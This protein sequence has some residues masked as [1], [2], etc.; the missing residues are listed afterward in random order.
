MSLL[1]ARKHF[2][3]PETTPKELLLKYIRNGGP[4]KKIKEL[5]KNHPHLLSDPEILPNAT[6][7]GKIKLIKYLINRGC[8]LNDKNINIALN[9]LMYRDKSSLIIL[10]YLIETVCRK[11]KIN[12]FHINLLEKATMFRKL[13]IIT[14]LAKHFYSKEIIKSNSKVLLK[15]LVF[16]S[17]LLKNNNIN[18][19]QMLQCLIQIGCDPKDCE[20][21]LLVWAIT[22]QDID[23]LKYII[24]MGCDPK[25]IGELSPYWMNTLRSYEIIKYLT[26]LSI[27]SCQML[28]KGESAIMW[29]IQCNYEQVLKFLF[30][31]TPCHRGVNLTKVLMAAIENKRVWAFEYLINKGVTI[32]FCINC[33]KY[34]H[35]DMCIQSECLS[36]FFYQAHQVSS[37]IFIR[38][39]TAISLDVVPYNNYINTVLIVGFPKPSLY[40]FNIFS[41]IN[42]IKHLHEYYWT[43][44]HPKAKS[45]K[46]QLQESKFINRKKIFLKKILRPTSMAIQLVFI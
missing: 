8:E 36:K 10:K 3:P 40:S 17:R 7:S 25:T 33:K 27:E 6:F 23:A 20:T 41:K 42:K 13:D 5:L 32:S 21:K 28:N 15:S 9:C 11:N 44:D 22:M 29:A 39:M 30:E 12:F 38:Y 31:E 46:Q 26:S 37:L 18:N 24:S 19:V 1:C 35:M 34:V 4:M 43:G 2:S 16:D 14:Y 45:F